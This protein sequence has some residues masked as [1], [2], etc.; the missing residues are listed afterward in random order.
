MAAGVWGMTAAFIPI[1]DTSPNDDPARKGD[2][3]WTVEK[4]PVSPEPPL[5]SQP[6]PLLKRQWLPMCGDGGPAMCPAALGIDAFQ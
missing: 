1:T 6:F 4:A 2:R 3:G 5:K